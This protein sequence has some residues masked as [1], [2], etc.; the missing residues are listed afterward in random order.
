MALPLFNGSGLRCL[1]CKT[2]KLMKIKISGVAILRRSLS[3]PIVTGALDRHSV[4][5]ALNCVDIFGDFELKISVK[6]LSK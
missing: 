2:K 5:C 4:L 6:R 1:C 3:T